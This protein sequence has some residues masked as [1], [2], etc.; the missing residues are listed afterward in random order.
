MKRAALFILLFGTSLMFLNFLSGC[1]HLNVEAREKARDGRFI[2][3]DNEA[4][5]DTR[6]NLM[7]AAYDNGSDLNWKNAKSYC[8]NYR[9]GGYNDWRM[10]TQDE[11]ATLYDASKLRL[12]DNRVEIHVAT[13]LID[14]TSGFLWASDTRAAR[15]AYFCFF[16]EGIPGWE[17]KL[18]V[19]SMRV[20]PVRSAKQSDNI[21]SMDENGKTPL[22]RAVLTNDTGKL[23]LQIDKGADFNW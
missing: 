19:N 21:N 6:T 9:G 22:H 20:L 2:A 16:R 13:M 8:N 10:P 1:L 14:I 18:F 5:L 12:N 11:L 17:E 3:Y 15:A 23:A 4:V 7:W